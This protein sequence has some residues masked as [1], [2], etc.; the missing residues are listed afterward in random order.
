VISD[1]L[2]WLW[3]LMFVHVFLCAG[4]SIRGIKIKHVPPRHAPDDGAWHVVEV[5]VLLLGRQEEHPHPEV[6]G[7]YVMKPPEFVFPCNDLVFEEEIHIDCPTAPGG[8]PYRASNGK[9]TWFKPRTS[10]LNDPRKVRR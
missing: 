1:G 8:A 7:L 9:K 4:K 5:R 6:D 3:F 2:E 10:K